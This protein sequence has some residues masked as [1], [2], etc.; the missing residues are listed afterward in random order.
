MSVRTK[1]ISTPPSLKNSRTQAIRAQ[2]KGVL[3]WNDHNSTY[4]NRQQMCQ[5][6][7]HGFEQESQ[8]E[9]SHFPRAQ[10]RKKRSKLE[11]GLPSME[12]RT[13]WYAH[14]VYKFGRRKANLRLCCVLLTSKQRVPKMGIRLD[15]SYSNRVAFSSISK[16]Q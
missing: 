13:E 10:I 6:E 3:L 15:S 4:R 12:S 1:E 5:K 11:V 7:Q 2:V 9:I 16:K 14:N 8:K